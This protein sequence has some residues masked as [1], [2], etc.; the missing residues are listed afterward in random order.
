[1]IFIIY[2]IYYEH[3]S[4]EYIMK[5]QDPLSSGHRIISAGD[6]TYQDCHRYDWRTGK[7]FLV[8]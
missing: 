3:V 2:F 6:N 7:W 5:T 1:M 8:F 4:W